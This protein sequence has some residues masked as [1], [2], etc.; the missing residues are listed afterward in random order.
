M[1]S[2]NSQSPLVGL[3]PRLP[4]SPPCLP[5]VECCRDF[6]L[7]TNKFVSMYKIFSG[8]MLLFWKLWGVKFKQEVMIILVLVVDMYVK[9]LGRADIKQILYFSRH[10]KSFCIIAWKCLLF[11]WIYL[12]ARYRVDIKRAH[13]ETNFFF[14][15][16]HQTDFFGKF[17]Y[18]T[19][20]MS[21]LFCWAQETIN[22]TRDETK[23]RRRKLLVISIECSVLNINLSPKKT[24]DPGLAC[25]DNGRGGIKAEAGDFHQ[26][27][28]KFLKLF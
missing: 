28:N 15:E 10:K 3:S 5:R 11:N 7:T 27:E 6:W 22:G 12:V 20:L 13:F 26:I 9:I 17:D 14:A 4:W 21:G 19:S 1:S 23:T 16:I 24:L 18:K 8:E 2:V 25:L